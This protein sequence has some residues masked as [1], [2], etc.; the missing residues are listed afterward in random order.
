[1]AEECPVNRLW[2]FLEEVRD[3]GAKPGLIPAGPLPEAEV[4]KTLAVSILK[5]HGENARPLCGGTDILIQLRA[6]VRRTEHLVDVK[7]I[8]ELQALSF[9][10]KNG[11]RLGAAVPCI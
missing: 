8:K 5:A 6:G 9:D 11:L 2:Q 1:M 4:V 7:K 3:S 10:A